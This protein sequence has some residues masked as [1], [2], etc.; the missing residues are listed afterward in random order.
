MPAFPQRR[1]A[2][3]IALLVATTIGAVAASPAN[4][5]RS[6]HGWHP[7]V[8]EHNRPGVAAFSFFR[9]GPATAGAPGL[10]DPFFPLAGNGGYDVGHYTLQLAYDPGTTVLNGIAKISATATQ[11]LSSFDLDLR[12]FAISELKVDGRAAGFSRSGQELQITPAGSLRAGR[13]FE[14]TVRYSGTPEVVTDPDGSIE[15]WVPT[16]DGAFVVGE[17][18]GSPGWFPSN[19]NPRDKATYDISVTVPAGL[20]AVSNGTL[21]GQSTKAG[22]TTFLWHEGFPMATYLATATLGN[23]DVQKSKIGGIPSYVAVDPTQA[24]DS[25]AALSQLPEIVKF[26]SSLYGP[27]PFDSVGAIV[28]DAPEVGYALESQTKPNY[29]SAPGDFTVAHETSHQ[30]FGDAVTLATWPDIWLHEGFATYSEWLWGEHT[31]QF[32][33]QNAFDFYYSFPDSDPIWSPPAGDPG[34]PAAL[35]ADSVYVRGAMTLQALRNKVGDTTFFRILRRWYSQNRY[36]NGTTAQFIALAGRESQM[37]LGA[38]FHA[39]LYEEGKP[40]M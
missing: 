12:G 13:S 29:D 31:G 28:D 37:D 6:F 34:D 15:G 25:A 30:W 20:T 39:W 21:L 16:S 23:F 5:V 35:F 24:A 38:L 18:Q 9:P 11:N 7:P 8:R 36:G 26:F 22:R 10:G 27:Y 17:P 3:L 33:P 32:T 2:V 19:D 1:S 4:A 40:S 14:V